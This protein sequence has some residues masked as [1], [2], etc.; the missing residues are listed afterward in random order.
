MQ[1]IHLVSDSSHPQPLLPAHD[2]FYVCLEL[3]LS[4]RLSVDK[5]PQSLQ[6]AIEVFG[7]WPLQVAQRLLH[8]MFPLLFPLRYASATQPQHAC[9][10]LVHHRTAKGFRPWSSFP[11]RK[12]GSRIDACLQVCTKIEFRCVLLRVGVPCPKGGGC[13]DARGLLCTSLKFLV[14]IVFC[15]FLVVLFG[16]PDR[17]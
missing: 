10:Q 9:S 2:R 14:F 11:D 3:R 8:K 4:R 7:L 13:G 1:T 16:G 12:P 6:P 17:A 5:S 15:F